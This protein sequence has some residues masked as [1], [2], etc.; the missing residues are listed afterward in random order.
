MWA[1]SLYLF[2]SGSVKSSIYFEEHFVFLSFVKLCNSLWPSL[3]LGPLHSGETFSPLYVL[4]NL[5]K[6]IIFVWIDYNFAAGKYRLGLATLVGPQ[7]LALDRPLCRLLYTW[8]MDL[9]LMNVCLGLRPLLGLGPPTSCASYNLI[10]SHC[11][12]SNFFSDEGMLGAILLPRA[13]VLAFAI[14]VQHHSFVL[15]DVWN[16][17]WWRCEGA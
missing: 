5:W 17:P 9:P 13:K 11:R 4:E 10:P 1:S 12:K 3:G 16:C 8:Y 14:E 6:P 7:A 2:V 15:I